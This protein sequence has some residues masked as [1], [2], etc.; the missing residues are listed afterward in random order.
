[1]KPQQVITSSDVLD[2]PDATFEFETHSE[3]PTGSLPF[4]SDILI[5]ESSGFHFGMSQSAGMGRDPAE[6]LR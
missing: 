4:T 3:G 6:L 2:P 1:M 5:N